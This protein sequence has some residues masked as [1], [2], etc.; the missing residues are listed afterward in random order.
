MRSR[1]LFSPLR[2]FSVL[3]LLAALILTIINL[4]QYSR[5]QANFPAGMKIAGVPVGG[6]DRQLAAQRLVEAYSTPIELVYNQAVIQVS[7]SVI[8]FQLD[9]DS[10]LAAA[11]LQRT[12]KN[13]WVGFWDFLW[14]RSTAPTEV[15]LRSTYSEVTLASLPGKRGRQAL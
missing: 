8:D 4:V 13:F 1:S 14:G 15:P 7:P 12:Q 11:D 10:M 2:W 5:T 6:M 3:F 9:L